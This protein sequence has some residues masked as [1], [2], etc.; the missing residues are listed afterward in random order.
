[1]EPD[2]TCERWGHIGATLAHEQVYYDAE[3][4]VMAVQYRERAKFTVSEKR[5]PLVGTLVVIL[6]YR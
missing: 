3:G 2:L 6:V 4:R 5:V 1:M